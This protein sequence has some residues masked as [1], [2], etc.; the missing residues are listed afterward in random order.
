M[1]AVVCNRLGTPDTVGIETTEPPEL[2]PDRVRV[3]V[4]AAGVNFV[5]GL[6]VSGEYQI[7]PSLPFT[8]GSELAGAVSAV[9]GDVT[10]WSVGDRVMAS[11]GLGAF[12]S[13]IDLNPGQLL[14]TPER[15]SDAQAATLGQSY[16]TAWFSL[17]RR[18]SV[19]AG[20]WIVILGASG[21]VGLAS[22]DVAKAL[23]LNTI[24]AASSRERLD[25]CIRR[26]AHEVI[27]YSGEDL[28]ARVREITGG[29]ADIVIDPVGG[30]RT[31]EALRALGDFGRLLV[32]GFAAGEIPRLPANQV[33]LRNRSALGVDWGIW[34]LTNPALNAA[35]MG[36]VLEAIEAGSLDPVEPDT[37]P[38]EEAGSAMADLLEHRVQG[39]LCL[40]TT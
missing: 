9:G 11:I 34:A 15:L 29:G 35:M 30:D 13:E 28:K 26:G 5:D 6:F 33:L 21:G 1:R 17:T 19:S 36:E 31:E 2:A 32:I 22:L 7:K 4:A 25:R 14:R 38:L 10:G 24:A 37:R 3:Q 40:T 27:D 8:P 20:E 18:T 39:K 23:G 16:A 12:T